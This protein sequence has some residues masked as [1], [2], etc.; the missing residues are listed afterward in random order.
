VCAVRKNALSKIKS[1]LNAGSSSSGPGG[2]LSGLAALTSL[3]H[4]IAVMTG[5]M[6]AVA[7]SGIRSD[8]LAVQSSY[9][10]A[11][12]AVGS[13]GTDPIGALVNGVASGLAVSDSQ[14]RVDAWLQKNCGVV[15]LLADPSPAPSIGQ[16]SAADALSPSA[17]LGKVLADA[18]TGQGICDAALN[19]GNPPGP[20]TAHASPVGG[21]SSN[22]SSITA[23]IPKLMPHGEAIYECDVSSA[24]LTTTTRYD[25]G[26][27][28]FKRTVL[29]KRP[30]VTDGDQFLVGTKFVYQFASSTTP[31][32]GLQAESTT[33]SVAAIDPRSGQDVWKSPFGSTSSDPQIQKGAQHSLVAED[34][35]SDLVIFELSGDPNSGLATGYSLSTGKP[36]WSVNPCTLVKFGCTTNFIDDSLTSIFSNLVSGGVII[37]TSSTNG[38]D[39]T[40]GF[41]PS[42]GK[43]VWSDANLT[44]GPAPATGNG[45]SN[46]GVV[47]GSLALYYSDSF[48]LAVVNV[49]NGN[50][51]VN[52]ALPNSG[53]VAPSFNGYLAYDGSNLN[54]FAYANPGTAKW[55]VPAGSTIPL[56]LGDTLGL[57][58]GPTGGT[59]VKVAGGSVFGNVEISSTSE[60]GGHQSFSQSGLVDGLCVG[61]LGSIIELSVPSSIH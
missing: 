49:A 5:D 46:P 59:L 35:A 43:L 52:Q 45:V 20:P 39:N 7:P 56:V 11:T 47:R 26:F 34:P 58:W 19:G 23:G 37:G 13:I 9:Q 3:P 50:I 12:K 51:L 17:E 40:A 53:F 44:C 4:A 8:L 16:A 36:K 24:H 41:D 2:F 6:A 54:Y 57:V 30:L 61:S 38:A 21:T 55:S 28:L 48:C 18:N 10:Q 29:W 31:A 42:T 32:S 25:V 1:Q 22:G 14:Q 27:D 15:A 33:W 60:Y